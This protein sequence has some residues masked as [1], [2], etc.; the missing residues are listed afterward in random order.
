[1]RKVKAQELSEKFSLYGRW[2]RM[3]DPDAFH[4]GAP[5]IEFYRD[6]LPLNA[7]GAP[8]VSFSICR[9]E[10]RALVVDV[11]EYHTACGEG[12]L[13]L[14]ADVLV[15]VMPAGPR[16]APPLGLLE[17]FRVPRGTMVALN[18]GVWHHAPLAVGAESASVL[19][20]LPERTYANDC[21]VYT[22]PE[23]DRV[24]VTV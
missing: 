23:N 9:V 16:E 14:D 22:I 2:A 5:P 18:P 12:I 11:T 20:V 21:T 19:I 15:H 10:K 8:V 3:V 17:V 1:M 4:F 7:G 13:P 24:A 6:L